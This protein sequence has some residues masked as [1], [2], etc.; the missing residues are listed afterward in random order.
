M[1]ALAVGI[2]AAMILGGAAYAN[3]ADEILGYWYT[4]DDESIVEVEKVDGKY[5]GTIIWLADP[6]YEPGDPE[7]GQPLRDREN[8]DK[9][10]QND[11]VKGLQVL[12]E[13]VYDASD[14]EWNSGTIY[15]P[16]NGRTYKCV[17]R[18]KP[19]EKGVD[20]KALHVRGYIG[21]PTL[22]RTTV[23]YRVPKDELEEHTGIES[24]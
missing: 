5:F 18:F 10:K 4:E 24:E 19:D 20:G 9:S 22:G 17:I 7:E 15:D 12:K 8:P 23:W 16:A 11:P 1:R 21:I 6:V 13:F 3:E 14:S 2:S